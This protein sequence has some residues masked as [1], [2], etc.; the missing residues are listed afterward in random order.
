MRR[1]K[2]RGVALVLAI[3]ALCILVSI[4][5]ST[6]YVA[7]QEVRKS[8]NHRDIVQAR[9]N[10]ESGLDYIVFVL[11][12]LE[13]HRSDDYEEQMDIIAEGICEKMKCTVEYNAYA[14]EISSYE[15]PVG[16][17]F[18]CQIQRTADEKFVII[19]RGFYN[20]IMRTIAIEA[21]MIERRATIFDYGV[22]CRGKIDLGGNTD[23][24]GVPDPELASVLSMSDGEGAITVHGNPTISGDLYLSG[25]GADVTINGQPCIGGTSNPDE[26]AEHIHEVDEPDMPEIDVS[27][28]IPYATNIV[29]SNS[30]KSKGGKGGK[31]PVVL[32][33][34]II[35]PGLNPNVTSDCVLNGVIYIKSPNQVKFNGHC[36]VNGIIVTEDDPGRVLRDCDVT[37]NGGATLNGVEVLS[38]EYGEIRN[39]K[40][41]FIVAPGFSLKFSGNCE[42]VG[43]VIAGDQVTFLGGSSGRV[44]GCVLGLTELPMDLGGSA[45]VTITDLDNENPAGFVPVFIFRPD[46]KTYTEVFSQSLSF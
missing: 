3:I 6:S 45:T 32:S 31:G 37:F 14:M 10:A 23:V 36:T 16:G 28:I 25:E 44:E 42:S 43:G 18:E 29:D 39:F 46:R 2:K 20:D 1:T 34:I 27:E 5:L 24:V 7:M 8:A 13:L 21:D 40:H 35:P 19:S 12:K 4:G 22:A 30:F 11:K 38:P 33:N 41:T 15:L 9:M 17:Q 26:Y